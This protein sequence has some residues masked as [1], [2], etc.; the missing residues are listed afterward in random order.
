[1]P[2]FGAHLSVAGGVSR[3]VDRARDLGCDCLQI[4]VKPPQQWRFQDLDAAEIARFRAGVEEADLEPVVAHASYLLN[5]AS[6]D[7]ALYEQSVACLLAEWDRAEALGLAGIVLHPGSH[8]E[9]GEA[10]GLARV[11]QAL[12]RLARARPDR[13]VPVLLETTAG[14][15]STLGATFEHLAQVFKACAD[16]PP[17]GLA[18]DTCHLWAAGYDVASAEGLDAT[19]ADLDEAVGL[20]RLALVHA[21]DAK[22][23]RGSRLDRHAAIGRGTIGRAGFRRIVNHPSLRHL[24]FILETPKEDARGRPMDPV[25][26]R[27]LRRLVQA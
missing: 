24:P 4:F 8:V 22:G 21:N 26:L 12:A 16:G 5:L 19:L 23:E 18:I 14:A 1:M 27:T 13:T 15:G 20:D 25:N 9:S 7:D 2:R 3:A 17:L 10:A 11:A 6:P